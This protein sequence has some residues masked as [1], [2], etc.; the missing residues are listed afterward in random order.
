MPAVMP[1]NEML[2]PM[3]RQTMPSAPR[4][5][6]VLIVNFWRT[7]LSSTTSMLAFSL[8]KMALAMQAATT[9]ITMV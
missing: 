7:N 2:E 4:M 3:F 8:L 1:P 6:F 5:T 9:E